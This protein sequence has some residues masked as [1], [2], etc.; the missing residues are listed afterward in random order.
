M[1]RA[2]KQYDIAEIASLAGCSK[3]SIHRWVKNGKMPAPIKVTQRTH[4]WP[5]EVAEAWLRGE[6]KP[7][8]KEEAAEAA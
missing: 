2:K 5:A 1:E 3:M 4:R 8:L 6:W 7:E